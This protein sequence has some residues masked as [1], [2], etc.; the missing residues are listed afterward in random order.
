MR[1]T[2][3]STP[4]VS[5]TSGAG[6]DVLNNNNAA[7][8]VGAGLG[9]ATLGGAVFVGAVVAPG[10]VVGYGLTSA[11][12]LGLGAVQDQK[13][14]VLFFLDDEETRAKNQARADK[15][16]AVREATADAVA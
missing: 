7:T 8:L 12:L 11:A 4:D 14:S 1:S 6:F 15:R 16:R 5:V 13:G 2:T 10:Q 9:L 3:V